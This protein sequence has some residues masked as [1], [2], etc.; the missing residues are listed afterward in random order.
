MTPARRRAA[1][2][3]EDRLKDTLRGS[4]AMTTDPEEEADI[5]TFNRNPP[6]MVDM[7][8]PLWGIITT[9]GLFGAMLVNMYINVQ[10]LST[11]MTDVQLTLK[12]GNNQANSNA[13]EIATIKLRLENAERTYRDIQ[14][15]VSVNQQEIARQLRAGVVR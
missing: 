6:R 1:D 5:K 8:I 12:A 2:Q 15:Q 11:A 9:A 13:I 10:Q 14:Q 3:Q 4:A 7:K